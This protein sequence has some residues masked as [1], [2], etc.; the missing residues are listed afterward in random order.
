MPAYWGLVVLAVGHAAMAIHH[1]RHG[2]PILRLMWR[3]R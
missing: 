2:L 3:G 1:H